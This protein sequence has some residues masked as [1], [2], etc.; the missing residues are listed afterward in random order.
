[1]E[2][3]P[4]LDLKANLVSLLGNLCYRNRAVQDVLR[5]EDVF[6][7]LLECS[8]LDPRNVLIKE[9]SVL[10]FRNVCENNQLNQELI[11]SY[12][13]LGVVQPSILKNSGLVVHDSATGLKIRNC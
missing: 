13:R 2:Q 9:R 1:M 7:T 6:D 4:C 11:E 8:N 10:A 12:K 3:H 5:T